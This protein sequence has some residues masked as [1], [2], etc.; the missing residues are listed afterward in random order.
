MLGWR[1]AAASGMEMRCTG[2][3]CG[4]VHS[5]GNRGEIACSA[6]GW[7]DPSGDRL[8]MAPARCL[9]GVHPS[10]LFSIVVVYVVCSAVGVTN[11]GC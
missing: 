10:L 9:S 1:M 8:H 2:L 6:H 4:L 7:G 5:N 3:G 11:L